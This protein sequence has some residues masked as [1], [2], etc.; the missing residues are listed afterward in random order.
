MLIPWADCLLWCKDNDAQMISPF[1]YKLRV[2]PIIR[3]ERDKRMYY[4]YFNSSGQISGFCRLMLLAFS[5]WVSAEEWRAGISRNKLVRKTV[6]SFT[7]MNCF[8]RLLGRQA[9]VA[10]GLRK[11]I[12]S[13]YLPFGLDERIFIGIHIRLGDFPTKI[14]QNDSNTGYFRLPIE[15][16]T[17][18]LQEIR[19]ALGTK[20]DAVIFSDGKDSELAPLLY[21]PFVRRSPF[22]IAVTDLLALSQSSI[23]ITSRSTFSLW[24]SYLGQV[25]SIWYPPKSEIC[26]GGVI[27]NEGN[28]KY[29]V[30]WTLGE[31]LP[32]DFIRTVKK[33]I[34]QTAPSLFGNEKL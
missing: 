21:L 5:D 8:D 15:W 22:K 18:C 33:R 16:Y 13:E 3:H 26:G 19:E 32:D 34:E 11:V 14:V 10:A 20:I 7:D 30:E 29:E 2:G 31:R 27:K 6:V 12:R 9:E 17:A 28:T 25:P 24:G 1:W 23:I 4:H